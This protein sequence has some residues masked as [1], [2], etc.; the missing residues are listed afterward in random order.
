MTS[1]QTSQN[2]LL[3]RVVTQL[4]A[5]IEQLQQN[6]EEQMRT[7]VESVTSSLE[8]KMAEQERLIGELREVVDSHSQQVAQ[9]ETALDE[10]APPTHYRKSSPPFVFIISWTWESPIDLLH[11]ACSI[12]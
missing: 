2:D 7:L 5:E 12:Y 10:L 3:N 11:R 8:S 4:H 1:T 9:V 6:T